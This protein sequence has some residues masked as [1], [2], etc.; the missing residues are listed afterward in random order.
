MA[1]ELE[2]LCSK[3]SLT[4]GEKEGIHVMEGD[5]AIGREMGTRCLVGKLW[6]ERPAN[7]EA[8]K[9][10]FSRIWRLAKTVVFKELQDNLWLFEF[11]EED[12]KNRVM[13]GRPWS[14]DRHILVLKEFDGHC[15]PSQMIFMHSPIW[16]QIHDMPLLCMTK[17]VGSKIGDSLGE[18]E[19][20][21][22][23]G[24]GVGWGRCLRIRVSIDLSKPLER[25]RA[26]V[27]GG[28]SHWVHFKYE[29]LPLF[30]FLC[31]CIVHGQKGCPAVL[32]QRMSISD[33]EKK[34]GAWLRADSVWRQTNLAPAGGGEFSCS[35][36]GAADRNC[37][38]GPQARGRSSGNFGTQMAHDPS[39]A[40][41]GSYDSVSSNK[42]GEMVGRTN[43]VVHSE[44]TGFVPV[45]SGLIFGR[46][47]T[48]F[49][50]ERDGAH[51]VATWGNGSQPAL[52]VGVDPVALRGG[53]DRATRGKGA[54]MRNDVG[55]KTGSQRGERKAEKLAAGESE[56]VACGGG[57]QRREAQMDLFRNTL[58]NCQLSDL[59]FIGPKFTW[60]NSRFDG[61]YIR[62]RLDRAVA[63]RQLCN[64][65]GRSVVNVLA[66]YSSDH[67]PLAMT[68]FSREE[69]EV[70]QQRGFKVEASWMLDDEYNGIVQ[71]AWDEGELGDTAITTAR[72]KLANCQAD[73]KRWSRKKF[74]NADRELKKK[75]KQLLELQSSFRV[76]VAAD[77]KRL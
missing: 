51:E 37:N 8:F 70:R 36:G 29:K 33:K 16:I 41:G 1:D 15:P 21:D 72:L 11:E 27:L 23:A 54:R 58:E 3:V 40:T 45:T 64:L 18:L 61:T 65:H 68:I 76:G 48:T 44:Y 34:W 57:I 30:C 50:D 5:V 49:R 6:T 22:V 17:G 71:Q 38:G 47:L 9:T 46:N 26:L 39:H 59:G 24:D 55:G 75:R 62:E 19:D 60:V 53:H 28:K 67:N 7:K 12:D 13:A 35:E 4:E 73:L 56:A 31:G 52:S 10:V 66:A 69:N 14:F 42:V 2:R 77:V 25:G 32:Q 74:G 43:D 20:V 63:N